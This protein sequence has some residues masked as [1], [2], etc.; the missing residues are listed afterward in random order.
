MVYTHVEICDGQLTHPNNLAHAHSSEEDS[1][2]ASRT[3]I[4][5]CLCRYPVLEGLPGMLRFHK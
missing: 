3:Y 5:Q 2:Y 4:I 1:L